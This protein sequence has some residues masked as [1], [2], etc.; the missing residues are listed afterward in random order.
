MV[1]LDGF[2][3]FLIL[4]EQE[5]CGRLWDYARGG[6]HK[7]SCAETSRHEADAP[8]DDGR[9]DSRENQRD[10]KELPG[11]SACLVHVPLKLIGIKSRFFCN[12]GKRL[13]TGE[14]IRNPL[15]L[16]SLLLGLG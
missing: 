4:V 10:P 9:A 15:I 11:F 3:K 8:N 14:S 16:T 2:S 12:P 7:A 5:E 6:S 1:C 13:L